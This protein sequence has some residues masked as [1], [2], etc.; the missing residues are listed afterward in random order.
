[1]KTWALYLVAL[2][3]LNTPYVVAQAVEEKAAEAKATAE[4]AK[5][6]PT[7]TANIHIPVDYLELLLDPLTKDELLVEAEAWR[8]LVKTTAQQIARQEIAT[9]E[10]SAAIDAIEEAAEAE[11]QA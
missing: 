9:R 8:D 10:K 5:P 1:M 7:T 11:Q 4:K 6:A 2:L 3:C